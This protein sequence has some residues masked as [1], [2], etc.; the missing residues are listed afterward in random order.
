MMLPGLQAIAQIVAGRVLNSVPEGLLIAGFV[1]VLLQIVGRQSS[2][3]RFAAWFAA[4]LAIAGLPFIPSLSAG[5]TTQAAPP[6]IALPSWWALAIFTFCIFI[7]A[8]AAMRVAV[9]LCK[10]RGLRNGCVA[11]ATSELHPEL[12]DL[13]EQFQA[14][15]E[16]T[17]A[18]SPDVSVPTAVGFFHPAILLPQWTVHDL[19][20]EELKVILL[21]EFAHLQRRDDWTNLAQKLVRTLFFFHPAVWWIEKRLCLERE[22]A[23]DDLVLAKTGNP[24]AYAVCLVSLVERSLAEKSLVRRG[25][26]LAQAA[27]GHAREIS[28]RLA[29]I[30]DAGRSTETRV[31]GPAFAAITAFAGICLIV[32]PGAP[33][34]IGFAPQLA[35]TSL[36]KMTPHLPQAAAVPAGAVSVSSRVVNAAR[37]NNLR[38]AVERPPKVTPV[39]AG[40]EQFSQTPTLVGAGREQSTSEPEFL[41]VM[42]TTQY[43]GRGGAKSTFC[44]WHVTFTGGKQT[45][46]RAEVVA[47]SI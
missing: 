47:K 39:V 20:A 21:H 43:N 41:V 17:I 19:P 28:A 11:I 14:E 30:L 1:W 13:I 12:R 22:M 40:Y 31:F 32:L 7:T 45:A 9:G 29:Q 3:T 8:I 42:Q 26:A 5:R 46:F 4:L 10:L 36:A 23:C 2:G 16:V 33:Q 37:R 15:R 35:S 18:S 34:L 24:R 27:I 44:V 25:V 38:A 6:T